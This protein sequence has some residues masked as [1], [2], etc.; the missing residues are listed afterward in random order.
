[1]KK[2]YLFCLMIIVSLLLFSQRSSVYAESGL[3]CHG[4]YQI[5][6]PWLQQEGRT[7]TTHTITAASPPNALSASPLALTPDEQELWVVNPDAGSVTIIATATQQMLAEL[8]TGGEPWS[9]AI[10]PDGASVYVLDRAQ[11]RL[12]AFDRRRRQITYTVAV[13]GEPGMVALLP[14]GAYAFVTS[15]ATEEVI[16]IDTATFT[17]AHRWPVAVNPHALAISNDGDGDDWDETIVI[18]HLTAVQR[19]G[20]IEATNDGRQGQVTLLR[21]CA[22]TPVTPVP[23]LPDANG[24][25]SLLTSVAI[26][27]QRAW[28]AL[29]RASPALPNSVTQTLFA[30]TVTVN[31]PE[32]QEE[33]ALALPLNDQ[34]IFGSPINNPWAIAFAPDGSRL[35]VVAAGS[36]LVEV[37]DLRRPAAPQLVGFLPVGC[38]PRG[39][40]LNQAGD[41]GYVMNF[42]SRSVTVLDL[43]TLQGTGE[44]ETTAETLASDVLLGKILF[45]N[46]TNPK[47]S[48]GG[49]IACASCHPDGGTDNI[50]WI[51]PD[52]PRQTPPLWNAT[53]TLPWHWSAALDE[54]Q[55]VEST[56]EEIQHGLGLAPGV[57][58]P[59]LGAV[60]AGRSTDL[61]AVAAYLDA[62][63]RLPTLSTQAP[64]TSTIAAGRQLFIQQGCPA[65]HGGRHWTTSQM[66]GPAGTLDP[67][68]NGMVD[69]V[70]R[71]VGTANAQ[72]LRGATG[73]DPPALLGVAF[74]APYLHDGSAVTLEALLRSG[75]PRPPTT[76]IT[77][78]EEE[79][80][81]LAAFVHSIDS[82][83]APVLP[84]VTP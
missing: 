35:Y 27:E 8:P 53:R 25:P 56:F 1:M 11:G 71:Q 64:N 37:I 40:V 68:G 24:F 22:S 69:G 6:L 13:G 26:F 18:T 67:D 50:T 19:P 62:D 58:P 2:C 52:G 17:I 39:I 78:S 3:R 48:R 82:Q 73:F 10:A 66:P 72:D 65:C 20:G 42:L 28:V 14:S 47:L 43:K 77:L 5:Y 61:D 79:V 30:A 32:Q 21:P 49:W 57:E 76:P 74:T 38:N 51:F 4:P 15:A 83:T 84:P 46:A 81:Q 12:L 60:N 36:D 45:N 55:D 44:I 7:T 80:I 75:H 33:P 70:L 16:A 59:L 54:A 29:Q 23:L 34:T 31:L 9:V 41:R 63:I